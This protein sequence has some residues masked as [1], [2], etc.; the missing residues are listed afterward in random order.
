MSSIVQRVLIA[1]AAA[2][3]LGGSAAAQLLPGVGLPAL[4]PVNLPTRDLPVA[5]PVL[6]DLLSQPGAQEAVAPTLNTVSGLPERIA[7]APAATLLE[8]RRL[9]LRELIRQHPREL[10]ADG[11]GQPVRSRRSNDKG[12]LPRAKHRRPRPPAEQLLLLAVGFDRLAPVRHPLG[13]RHQRPALHLHPV[14]D[15]G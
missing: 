11:S 2:A 9:R 6:R 5:G 3:I 13:L 7:E 12:A 4:P 10:E 14:L 8:L 1:A 15:P